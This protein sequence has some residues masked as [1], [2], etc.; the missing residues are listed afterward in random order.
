MN[1]PCISRLSTI[2]Y[3]RLVAASLVL[4]FPLTL[5]NLLILEVEPVWAD[6]QFRARVS[7]SVGYT[8][9][10][11]PQP[12]VN[13]DPRGDGFSTIAPG[14][15]FGAF[16]S[17]GLH[18]LHYTFLYYLY[19]DNPEGNAYANELSY[20]ALFQLSEQSR[21]NLG[22]FCS[23]GQQRSIEIMR[24]AA[25]SLPEVRP[26]EAID[27]VNAGASETLSW[28]L[29]ALWYA[30]QGLTFTA[31]IPYSLSS[32]TDTSSTSETAS[33]TQQKNYWTEASLGIFH[34]W[35]VSSLGF[36]TLAGYFLNT[37]TETQERADQL[38]A[39][40]R[41]IWLQDLGPFWSLELNGGTMMAL[42][43]DNT[44]QRL[45][46]PTGGLNLNYHRY[47]WSIRLSANHSV[48]PNLLVGTTFLR[49]QFLLSLTYPLDRA[50]K[51]RL[52]SAVGYELGRQ[53]F[54]AED[55]Q[56]GEWIHTPMADLD[57]SWQ[58]LPYLNA[59]IR[60]QFYGQWGL[61]SVAAASD[62]LA[63]TDA[64]DD[65]TPYFTRHQV[66][67]TITMSYPEEQ[68]WMEQRTAAPNRV[69]KNDWERLFNAGPAQPV[70]ETDSEEKNAPLQ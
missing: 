21:L 51:W 3:G 52:S 70:E 48:E 63:Q 42:R 7:T 25:A 14:L 41:A 57:L 17:F 23:Q 15:D 31:F 45:F 50:E 66:L 20:N 19:F 4:G 9:N 61:D 67:L 13:P 60:Y 10:V 44:E 6:T 8:D 33:S 16:T 39:T 56:L 28:D 54:V 46:Q 47:I 58:A 68:A 34:R 32:P 53:L 22:L 40:L 38:M 27:F 43:L 29:S 5:M 64:G 37:A 49:E 65:G 35:D 18:Q 1:T 55:N 26:D 36:Q 30:N 59:A 12:A 24:E 11:S 62:P 2:R 69:N